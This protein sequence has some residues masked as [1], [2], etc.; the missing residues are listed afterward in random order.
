MKKDVL[1]NLAK[2]TGKHLWFE[3]FSKAPFLQNTPRRLRL[4]FS[5]SSTKIGYC[6]QCLEKLR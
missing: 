6:Q 2:F 1:E 4:A 5:C 3:K